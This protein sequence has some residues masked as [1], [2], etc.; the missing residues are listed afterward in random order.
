MTTESTA[1]ESAK[2]ANEAE[3]PSWIKP[4]ADL[5]DIRDTM[6]GGLGNNDGAASH[7]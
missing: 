6:T 1:S 2:A 4:E 3:R 5:I 7:T